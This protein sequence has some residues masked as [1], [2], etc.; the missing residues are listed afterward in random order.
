MMKKPL[1]YTIGHSTRTFEE[2]AGILR[3]YDITDLA[4]VRTM[5]RSR[6]NPQFNGDAL[7]GALGIIG[8]QYAHLPKLGG[9]RKAKPDS[10]NT[11]WRNASFRGYAD[12]MSTPEFAE[13]LEELMQIARE[14]TAAIMCAEAVPWR[15]HRS[16]VGD[17]LSEKGWD[18]RDIM[19]LEKASP[20]RL[21]PFLKAEDG[22]LTY[23]APESSLF[24]TS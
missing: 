15:C 16:L 9:V 4:D 8:I 12:Y 10:E 3:A 18:V 21:T 5:P 24:E 17:A 20:H 11:G 19:T 23:P 1:I 22:R 13:G 14:R 6:Y 2:F 7:E